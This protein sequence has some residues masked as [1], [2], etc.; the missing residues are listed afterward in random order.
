LWTCVDSAQCLWYPSLYRRC[1]YT[2]E[3]FSQVIW[4]FVNYN[5]EL[6]KKLTSPS[7][8]VLFVIETLLR[9]NVSNEWCILK[10]MSLRK[11]VGRMKMSL[12]NKTTY[13]R[14]MDCL[15]VKAR[16]WLRRFFVYNIYFIQIFCCSTSNK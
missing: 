2:Q 9:I 4:L 16:W 10:L 8:S 1:F 11:Y 14:R 5:T 7:W 6:P 3:Y 15:N 13:N 12:I